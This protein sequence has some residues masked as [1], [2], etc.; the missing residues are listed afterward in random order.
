MTIA[1]Q[2][3][4]TLWSKT[5]SL[6]P[7]AVCPKGGNKIMMVHDSLSYCSVLGNELNFLRFSPGT[8]TVLD[9][10]AIG[11]GKV[12]ANY[13]FEEFHEISSFCGMPNLRAVILI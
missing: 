1:S 4:T 9:R 10:R 3:S 13:V 6:K 8:K 2:K 11:P 12:V 7:I 5:D